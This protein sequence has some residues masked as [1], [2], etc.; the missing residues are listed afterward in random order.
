MIASDKAHGILGKADL[1]L[2]K[3]GVNEFEVH[4]LSLREC[5][6]PGA[7]VEVHLKGTEKRK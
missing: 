3:F 2:S 6:F 4:K 5:E 7:Q 1:D